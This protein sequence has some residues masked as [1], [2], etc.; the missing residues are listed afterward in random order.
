MRM[1]PKGGTGAMTGKIIGTIIL[2]VFLAV[3]VT[4]CL[5]HVHV[6]VHR[7]GVPGRLRPGARLGVDEHRSQLLIRAGVGAGFKLT[8][9]TSAEFRHLAAGT[10]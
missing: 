5:V 4:G 6:T 2:A 9:G 7:G 3:C 8:G 1:D 10:G